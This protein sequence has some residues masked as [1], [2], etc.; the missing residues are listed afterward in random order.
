M[1]RKSHEAK[2]R[3]EEFAHHWRRLWEVAEP[4]VSAPGPHALPPSNAD[5]ESHFLR[6][7]EW[8]GRHLLPV[9]MDIG[10][11]PERAASVAQGIRTLL[12][13][14]VSLRDLGTKDATRGHF[15]AQWNHT[16]NRLSIALSR[17]E[18]GVDKRLI[19]QQEST[20]YPSGNPPKGILPT[21]DNPLKRLLFG[22]VWVLFAWKML[23]L[24]YIAWRFAVES[25]CATLAQ[26]G[27]GDAADCLPGFVPFFPWPG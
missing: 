8:V 15:Q 19:A 21:G 10:G 6:E 13:M 24:A 17:Y 2:E 27:T 23:D 1:K 5:D 7:R 22:V 14:A 4:W 25:S 12:D 26:P 11:T 3:L 16:H 18:P 20:L 9:A